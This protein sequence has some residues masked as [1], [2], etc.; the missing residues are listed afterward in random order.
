M[1]DFLQYILHEVKNKRLPKADAIDLMRQ[2]QTRS[3]FDNPCFIHPLLHRNSSDL[4]EQRFSSTFTGEEFFLSDH[5][6]KGQRLLPGVAYIEMARAAVEQAASSKGEHTG[7]RLK[8]VIWARPVAVGDH[9][10]QLHIGLFPEDSG[11]I[12]FEIYT[13]SDGNGAEP[14]VHSQGSAVLGPVV[15][16]SPLDLKALQAQCSRSALSRS[17]CYEAFRAM[18]I[19][20]GPGHQGIEQVYVG[21]GQALAKLSLPLSVFDTQ[22]QFVLHPSIMDSA[23]QATI[24]L[25][26]IS[27]D[28]NDKASLKPVLPF[29]LQE[30]EVFGRCTPAMWALIRYREG[31]KAGDTVQKL[32]IDVC[33]EQGKI[34][35]RMKGFSTRVLEGEAGSIGSSATLGTLMLEPTWKEQAIARE[36]VA[37][38]Y[39]KHIVMLCEPGKVS[40]ESIESQ[41]NGVRCIILQSDQQGIEERF[42]TYAVQAFEEIQ[43]ILKDRPKGKV[44]I[45]IVV[46]TGGEQR[47]LAGL[48]GLLKTAQLENPKLIGQ[49]IEVEPGQDAQGIVEKLTENSRCPNDNDIQIRYQDGKRYVTGWSEIQASPEVVNIPWKDGGVYLIT[50]GAGG[51]GLIFV[52]EITQKVKDATLILTGR[53]SLKEDKQARLRELEKLGS[54]MIY[55]QV[56]M[57]RKE[58]V[59]N[60]IQSVQKD[61]GNINGII[62]GAG[63]IRDSFIIKKTKEEFLEVMAPKVIGLVNLDNASKE[64]PVDFFILFSSGVGAMGNIGQCDYAAANAFMDAYAQYR[65]ALVSSNQRHGQTLSINWPLWKE[66]GMSVDEA[67]EKMLMQS[68]GMIAMRTE[69]GIR[70]LYQGLASGKNRVMVMEGDLKRLRANFFEQQSSTAVLKSSSAMERKRAVSAIAQDVLEEKAVNYF[71]MLFSSALKMPAHQIEADAPMGEYGIDSIMA[72]QL[73]NQLEETFGSLSKTLLFEYQDIQALTGYFLESYRDRLIE[74]LGIEEKPETSNSEFNDSVAVTG[75][76]TSAINSERRSRFASFR[77]AFPA[78][79]AKESLDIAI[80]GVSGRYPQARTIQELWNNLRDGKDCITEIP[81]E[82]WDYRKYYNADKEKLG[83]S[84]SKWGG[85]IDDVD[86]F[87]PLFFDMSPGEATMMDPQGRLFLETVWHTL[88]DAGYTRASLEKETVG[89]YVGAMWGEYQLL[90]AEENFK[91]N[92]MFFGSSFALFAN[93]VSYYF[94]F[95][96]PSIAVDTMCSS[97]ITAIHL[98]CESVRSGECGVAVAGGVNLS[99]HW[100][101]Y[102]TLSQKGL[103]SSDGKCRSFGE[104]GDGYVPGE[105]VGAVLLKPLTAAIRDRD[106]IYAVIKGSSINAA[107]K[108]SG[109]SVPNPN[110]QAKVMLETLKKSQID[111][112]TISYIESFA[113][114]TSLGDPIEIAGLTKAFSEYTKD[115]QYCSIGAVKT[116][117]GHLESASGIAAL[118]KVLLQMKYKQLVPSL[119]SEKL[120]PNIPFEETPFYVQ[121]E[122]A[123]WKQPVIRENGEE[124][125]YPR[126]AGITAFAAGGSYGSLILEEYENPAVQPIVQQETPRIILLSAK[127]D[128]RLREYIEEFISFLDRNK[129]NDISLTDIAYTLQ[130]GREAMEKRLAVI[131]S[132]MQELYEKLSGY[133]QGTDDI[134]NCYTENGETGRKRVGLFLEGKSGEEFLNMIIRNRELSKVA[135]MWASGAVIDWKLFYS[136]QTAKRISLPTYPFARERYWVSSSP[137]AYNETGEIDPS[138]RSEKT[139]PLRIV[140]VRGTI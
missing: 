81:E 13:N 10:V 7:I 108:R 121:H 15:E 5:V 8:N 16:V 57:T 56:D 86:K 140:P 20:Y 128:E 35:V 87:D 58:A 137:G 109:F 97:S 61:F 28:T 46:P 14:V 24:G 36:A 106:N 48:S 6:V 80:I 64:L 17:R 114:G 33:D 126:R 49:L 91:G 122:L 63:V 40:Q 120:N 12:A 94:G 50:G 111:P 1:K 98:A 51:L 34:C 136:D 78:E 118:T 59:V 69:T 113:L 23:L 73:T 96:G 138:R 30:L 85:F 71:T 112:R 110:A 74:L 133:Y 115:K 19:E 65:T 9:P 18:G 47:L 26:M 125:R 38:Q 11:E 27:D 103:V 130:V 82:R 92:V 76:V 4:T 3:F 77:S 124:K 70:A 44:L 116:N 88:E 105:G 99:L 139:S 45:Q 104:G 119:H 84:Y 93:Q 123:E 31:S 25:M 2:F 129:E 79:K 107:G 100:N 21:E 134:E 37:P 131:V 83:K 66:G 102:N 67:T 132:S 52:K 39:E 32:D 55:R 43:V 117:T 62:H 89:V 90:G 29:A 75:P 135:Q 53:S 60:L 54:R 42:P 72:M 22:D 68:M 127:N 95:D 101:K 41:M